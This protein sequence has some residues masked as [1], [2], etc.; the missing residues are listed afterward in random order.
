MVSVCM[1]ISKDDPRNIETHVHAPRHKLTLGQKAADN[2]TVW[3]GSWQFIIGLIIVLLIWAALNVYLVVQM[4]WDPYP[5]I[6]LNLFLSTLAALQAPVILMSQNRTTERDRLKAE[7][8]YAVNRKAERE[9]ENMQADLDEIKFLVK[10]ITSQKK[11]Q[12]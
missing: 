4:R 6:L 2:L 12:K 3:G 11:P 5:F 8:D 1:V 7:R 9:I 10:S